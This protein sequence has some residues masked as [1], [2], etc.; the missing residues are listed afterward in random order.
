MRPDQF[1]IV[2]LSGRGDKVVDEVTRLLDVR[3]DG[4]VATRK[5]SL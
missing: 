2:N 3:E 1:I 4:G 5:C